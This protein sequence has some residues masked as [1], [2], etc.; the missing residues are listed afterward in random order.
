MEDT[1]KQIQQVVDEKIRPAL[2]AHGGDMKVTS[3]ENGIVYFDFMGACA[4]CPSNKFTTE[5]LVLG[6][7]SQIPGVTGVE[8]QETVSEE[9][10]DFARQILKNGKA[11]EAQ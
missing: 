8:M 2:Q 4:G 9:L 1:L 10:L 11:P 3:F 5:D 7:L 6:Q